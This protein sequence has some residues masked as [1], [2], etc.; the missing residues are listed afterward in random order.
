[1][2]KVAPEKEKKIFGLASNAQ[3]TV[4]K[5][6]L[7]RNHTPEV[8]SRALEQKDGIWFSGEDNTLLKPKRH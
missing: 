7:R 5:R 1:M 3:Y 4:V 8:H 6:S 2:W